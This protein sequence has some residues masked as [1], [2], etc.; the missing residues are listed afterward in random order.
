MIAAAVAVPWRVPS[1]VLGRDGAVSPSEKILLGGIGIE[2]RGTMVLG[3]MLLETG[4]YDKALPFLNRVRLDGP[5]SNQALLS[6]GWANM[7]IDSVV[8]NSKREYPEVGSNLFLMAN[9][10][11]QQI[12]QMFTPS[13]SI[14]EVMW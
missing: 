1:S 11:G 4:E 3:T 8:S 12:I 14:V 6:S 5:F 7:S 9:E 13:I 10:Q 2:S